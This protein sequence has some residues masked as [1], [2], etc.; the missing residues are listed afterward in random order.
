MKRKLKIIISTACAIA[1]LVNAFATTTFAKEVE[2]QSEIVTETVELPSGE[3]LSIEKEIKGDTVVV[4]AE[5]ENGE[6]D[7]VVNSNGIIY[8]NGERIE[9][10]ITI[11]DEELQINNSIVKAATSTIKWG[12]WSDGKSTVTAVHKYTITAIT[13]IIVAKLPHIAVTVLVPVATEII[14]EKYP[15]LH[16]RVQG[17]SGSSQQKVGPVIKK[18]LHAG[19]KT[20]ISGRN[21]K[22]GK[23]HHI[24]T[25][26]T[27]QKRPTN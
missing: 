3:E 9:E 10:F 23:N 12:K 7:Y 14:K 18:Y 5:N 20:T 17:R 8:L 2:N 27:S 6:I 13:A 19:Q 11:D 22:N 25:I 4:T 15:Y 26:Y 21:S 16:I 24:K 1:L